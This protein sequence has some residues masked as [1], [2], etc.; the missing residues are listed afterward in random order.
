MAVQAASEFVWAVSGRQFGA[1]EVLTRPCRRSCGPGSGSGSWWWSGV[2]GSGGW[3][4]WPAGFAGAWWLGAGCGRCHGHCGCNAADTIRLDVP[5]QAVSQVLI[6]G[7]VLPASGYAFY[8]GDTLVRTDGQL[9]PLCQDWSVSVSGVGAW[10]VTAVFGRP[11]PALGS[12]AVGE[13]ACQIVRYCTDSSCRLPPG[14]Q[15]QTRAGST[16]V[17]LDPGRLREAGATGFTWVDRLIEAE[18][19]GRASASARIWNPNDFPARRPT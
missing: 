5:A 18:N 7:E 19:P 11:V 6:D 14:L 3:P 10:S 13:V 17:Y 9:W 4:V 15:S 8:N 12:L 16:Y 1:C 2:A